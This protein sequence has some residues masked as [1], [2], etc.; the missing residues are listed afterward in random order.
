MRL[1]R[2]LRKWL[3]ASLLSVFVPVLVAMMLPEASRAATGQ[4][5]C[6]PQLIRFGEIVLGKSVTQPVVLTNT[7]AQN[8]KISAMS[9]DD[10]EFSVSGI[11]LPVVLVPGQSVTIQLHFAPN[12]HGYTGGRLVFT[13]NLPIPRLV[14]LISGYGVSHPA[15][16]AAT[17][18]ALSFGSV[19]LG[20][21]VSQTVLVSCALP[22]SQTIT[23]LS[24]EGSAFS[25][26]G[27]SLPVTLT[28]KHPVTLNIR[29]KPGAAGP[30]AGDVV[31]RGLGLSV[32]F[33]GTGTTSTTGKL[34]VS[35]TALSF[36][37][38]DIGSSGVQTS[39]LT[40]TG[41][42]VTVSSVSSSNAEF[43]VS[44]ASFPL[45]IPS[46]QST[47]A[48]IVFSPTKAGTASG[49]LTVRSDASDS[50]TSE[51]V[52][53]AGVTPKYSVALTWNASTSSVAGYN[54]YRGTAAGAYS[55][56]NATL[57]STTTY[58]DTTVVSGTTYYYSATAV[59]TSGQESG[60]S[61][62]LKVTIP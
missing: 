55:K 38:V 20:K 1:P 4:L 60:Y 15:P 3:S 40:A 61:T 42:S 12:Q 37:S 32:P 53:G 5:S 48:K 46:G 21:S 36:G 54:V 28:R 44:G 41:G 62:P 7:T 13:S 39:T 16:S 22:C 45:T 11:Q 35:P 26:S 23:G 59:A 43:G 10:S 17:P 49:T 50:T 19:P 18:S 2:S 8:A 9:M 31:V 30:T 6:S 58:T 56:I 25:V 33:M 29:F 47:E 34:T 51:S 52:N 27:P 24:V 57:D 14:V